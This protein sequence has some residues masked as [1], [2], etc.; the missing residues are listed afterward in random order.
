[1]HVVLD[2]GDGSPAVKLVVESYYASGQEGCNAEG[3]MGS[4]SGQLTWRWQSLN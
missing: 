1:M 3:V 2:F 4:G